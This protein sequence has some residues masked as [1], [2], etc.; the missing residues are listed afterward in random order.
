M[1]FVVFIL[2]LVGAVVFL[3]GAIAIS[4]MAVQD[5]RAGVKEPGYMPAIIIAAT[6]GTI[7]VLWGMVGLP[8]MASWT[9]PTGLALLGVLTVDWIRNQRFKFKKDPRAHTQA[10]LWFY[11]RYVL[12][13]VAIGLLLLNTP[14]LNFGRFVVGSLA[15]VTLAVGAHR[16]HR[17]RVNGQE[18]KKTDK[19]DD[20]TPRQYYRTPG[21]VIFCSGI[22]MLILFGL[23]FPIGNPTAWWGWT[24]TAA[25]VLSVWMFVADLM[26]G[27]GRERWIHRGFRLLAWVLLLCLIP[28]IAHSWVSTARVDANEATPP[29]SLWD[30]ESC[31]DEFVLANYELDDYTTEEILEA[32]PQ[33]EYLVSSDVNTFLGMLEQLNADHRGI[34]ES[35]LTEQNELRGDNPELTLDIE[36][37]EANPGLLN[38]NGCLSRTGQMIIKIV[39]EELGRTWIDE[40][41]R[42]YLDS[43]Q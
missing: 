35:G 6:L 43:R 31:S 2:S 41:V 10:K 18:R 32:F 4:V 19:E 5:H 9:L 3:G 25:I 22:V 30:M 29:P 33:T 14:M 12:V 24:L 28:M 11:L 26:G 1:S 42:T 17:G 38:T 21:A 7:C 20:D 37:I 16:Y 34:I 39:K 23:M 13:A 8:F 36:T 27:M 40:A 15:L